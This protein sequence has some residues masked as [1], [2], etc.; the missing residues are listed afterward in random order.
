MFADDRCSVGDSN[1]KGDFGS[2]GRV[3]MLL[4]RSP[5]SSGSFA[6]LLPPLIFDAILSR[7][8]EAGGELELRI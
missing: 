5:K 6:V 2:S 1:V 8:S 4:Q 3:L 7:S